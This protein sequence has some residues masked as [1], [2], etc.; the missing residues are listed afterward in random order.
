MVALH[1]L[2]KTLNKDGVSDLVIGMPHRYQVT[3]TQLI[4][5]GGD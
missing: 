1:T 5:K 4:S 2:F 3:E